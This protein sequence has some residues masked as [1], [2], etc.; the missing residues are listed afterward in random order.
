MSEPKANFAI[1]A[2]CGTSQVF[3]MEN[4][5]TGALFFAAMAFAS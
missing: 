2:L 1:Q 5:L 4:A 3:F